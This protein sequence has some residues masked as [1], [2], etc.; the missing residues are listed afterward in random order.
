MK[1]KKS[2]ADPSIY[3]EH[4]HVEKN[5]LE[6]DYTQE[7]LKRV[8]LPVNIISE[9]EKPEGITGF[10]P[11]NLGRGKK[12]LFLCENK[13]AFLKPCPGTN[14]YHCCDY[15]VI[16][17]GMNCP[18]DC[19]YCILQAYLNKPWISA[20]VNIDKLFNELDAAFAAEPQRFFRI[21]TGEF[22]DSLA[23]DNITGLSSKIVEHIA[24]QNNAVLELKTKSAVID[25]LE[26]A[27]HKGRTILSWSLN[28][29]IIMKREEIRS[30][31]LEERLE[32]AGR[33]ASW[34]Y[35]LGFHFDPLIIHDGWQEGYSET[36]KLLFQKVPKE[37]IVWIS[38]GALRYLPD[39][40][41][42]GTD[43]FPKSRIFYNEFI[44]G[45]DGKSRYFR[46][47]WEELYSHIYS[48]LKKNISPDTC[49]YFC[50]ESEELWQKVFGYSPEEK[51]GIPEMLD[52]AATTTISKF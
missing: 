49:I 3:I 6:L 2:W 24:K 48:Q 17:I 25:Q 33:A 35:L 46:S 27:D 47:Q 5:V 11:D 15:Q 23:L 12:H 7:I 43:R 13:G 51:G 40:K 21:G 31:S 9:G 30:A 26:Y 19:V 16:N 14:C 28:S 4:V 32:A 50:M 45:L 34:G 20:F 22:S 10:F 18:M 8:N 29:P 44:T 41:M 38:L 37:S 52:L 42:I 36:I 39:L 1:S